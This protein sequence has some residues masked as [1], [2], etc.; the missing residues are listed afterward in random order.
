MKALLDY[1]LDSAIGV[2]VKLLFAVEIS[3]PFFY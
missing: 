2:F 3:V 1:I